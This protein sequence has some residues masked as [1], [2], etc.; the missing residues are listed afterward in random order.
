MSGKPTQEDINDMDPAKASEA[1]QK[2]PD[3]I[4]G[5]KIGH[6]EGT[7]WTPFENADSRSGPI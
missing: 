3:I 2:Y 1:I 4:V 7:L 5:V 6:Y